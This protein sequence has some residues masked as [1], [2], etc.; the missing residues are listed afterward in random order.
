M[1]SATQNRIAMRPRPPLK[2]V[3]IERLVPAPALSLTKST[4]CRRGGQLECLQAYVVLPKNGGQDYASILVTLSVA[5]G[6]F[7]PQ[8]DRTALVVSLERLLA[9]RNSLAMLWPSPN[10]ATN[11]GRMR[12]LAAWRPLSFVNVG[13]TK[14]ALFAQTGAMVSARLVSIS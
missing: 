2:A 8:V 11:N 1:N 10:T 14:H 12:T 6:P 7:L 5:Q 4:P 13:S 3:A 9:A